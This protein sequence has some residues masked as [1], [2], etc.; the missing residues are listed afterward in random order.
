MQSLSKIGQETNKLQKIGDDITVTSFLKIAQQYFV[1][2]YFS[3]IAIH[4]PSFKLIEGQ[5]KELVWVVPNIPSGLRM[6]KKRGQ[7]RVNIS[8]SPGPDNFHPRILKE[9]SNE[10][11]E[12]L[13]LLFSKSLID[14][15]LPKTWKD[16]HVTPVYKKERNDLQETTGL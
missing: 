12:P 14:G 13:F 16:A 4:V 8:K 15:V 6:T 11:Y 10:L 3:L 5:I 9:L 7:D 1:C 2:E